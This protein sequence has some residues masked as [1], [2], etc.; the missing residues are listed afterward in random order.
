M[1]EHNLLA[2]AW[3]Q[4]VLRHCRNA[5]TTHARKL[6]SALSWGMNTRL[7]MAATM[8]GRE[9]AKPGDETGSSVLNHR[10]IYAAFAV[11][12][13]AVPGTIP[14]LQPGTDLS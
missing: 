3:E 4:I 10:R 5:A 12:K 1:H 8:N 11:E 14:G 6:S 9:A 2:D 7:P 13:R